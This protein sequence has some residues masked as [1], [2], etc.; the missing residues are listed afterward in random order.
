MLAQVSCHRHTDTMPVEPAHLL[1]TCC[2]AEFFSSRVTLLRLMSWQE[3][4]LALTPAIESEAAGGLAGLFPADWEAG[5]CL[6]QG[7][8]HLRR[9]WLFT[10][11][12]LAS[13]RKRRGT[14][15]K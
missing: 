8:N 14:V 12:A 5:M 9:P 15:M 6:C 4:I 13:E 7:G 10:R 3:E 11:V 1:D 2:P